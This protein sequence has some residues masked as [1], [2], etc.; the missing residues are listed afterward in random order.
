MDKRF[1]GILG[2]LV[3]IFAAIFAITQHSSSNSSNNNNASGTQPTHHIEGKGT[4]GVTLMEYGDYQCPICEAYYL[5][6]K[7]AVAQYS[8]QI[9]FQFRNLPLSPQPHPNAF[10]AARAAE[11]AAKQNKFWQMHDKLYDNQTEWA[12]A[13]N[14]QTF[15]NKYA[16]QIGLNVDQ[17]KQDYASG[18]VNNAI[19][20]DL[21]AFGKTGK[22]KATPTFFVNGVYLPNTGLVDPQTG[23]PSADKIGQAIQA[24][25]TKKNPSSTPTNNTPATQP[26]GSSGNPY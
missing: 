18:E 6:L 16:Q 10:A 4:S 25:I 15:Y 9:Y 22:E 14:P 19:N 5:P 23:A 2:A 20:A 26:T 24:E 7:Q 13:P 11:A 3:I 17:F 21:A 12:N 8:D 1:L